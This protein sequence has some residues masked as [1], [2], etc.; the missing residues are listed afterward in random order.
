MW[1]VIDTIVSRCHWVI[2]LELRQLLTC[3]NTQ[4][5]HSSIQSPH[6]LTQFELKLLARLRLRI[7]PNVP[8]VF[9]LFSKT[10]MSLWSTFFSCRVNLKIFSQLVQS[11]ER[12]EQWMIVWVEPSSLCPRLSSQPPGNAPNY[13]SHQLG[14]QT[15]DVWFDNSRSA[16]REKFPY[17]HHFLIVS[18]A[19]PKRQIFQEIHGAIMALLMVHFPRL[20]RPNRDNDTVSRRCRFH[21]I[22]PAKSKLKLFFEIL[23]TRASFGASEATFH[24]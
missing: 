17:V 13:P 19:K 23:P 18:I 20:Y 11:E 12:I 15:L 4:S 3:P 14:R 8:A 9:F 7:C 5:H 21:Q 1:S 16:I 24:W 6:A 2:H 10:R 22:K